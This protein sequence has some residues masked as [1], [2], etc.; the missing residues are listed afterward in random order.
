MIKML[1]LDIINHILTYRP[2]H[3]NALIIREYFSRQQFS[4]VIYNQNGYQI[5]IVNIGN[6]II[7]T[8]AVLIP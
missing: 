6:N 5:V 7:L 1:P 3:P 2:T 8:S 4:I